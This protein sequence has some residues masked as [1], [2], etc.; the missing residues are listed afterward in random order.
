VGLNIFRPVPIGRLLNG[1]LAAEGTGLSD[2][3]F[4]PIAL[5]SE[6]VPNP[7]AKEPIRGPC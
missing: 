2:A 7:A 3:H 6:P 1:M 4:T 5:S